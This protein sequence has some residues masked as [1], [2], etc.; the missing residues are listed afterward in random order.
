[1]QFISWLERHRRHDEQVSRFTYGDAVDNLVKVSA[2]AGA[3]D[4]ITG[5]PRRTEG[6]KKKKKEENKKESDD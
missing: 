5:K 2:Q 3:K 6:K 1:Y 4:F